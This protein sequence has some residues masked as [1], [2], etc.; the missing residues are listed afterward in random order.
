MD[1]ASEARAP[2]HPPRVSFRGV[3]PGDRGAYGVR[4]ERGHV[5][6]GF[7]D[8]ERTSDGTIHVHDAENV[9]AI[10]LAPGALGAERGAAVVLDP[11]ATGVRVS[12]GAADGGAR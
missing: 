5:G 12:F 9:R 2:E 4:F 8:V 11:A 3:R 1:K 6:D 7:V 10:V